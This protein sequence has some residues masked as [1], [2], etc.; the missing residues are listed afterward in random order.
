MSGALSSLDS[1]RCFLEAARARSFRN[2]AHAVGLTPTAFGQRIKQLEGQL[3]ARLFLRTTRSVTLTERGL[4]LV[5]VAERC[6]A[7]AEE[8][9][10]IARGPSGPPPMDLTL[11]TRQELGMSWVVPMRGRL[12]RERPWLNLHLYF[13]SGPD[14]L[15]RVRTLDIDCAVTSSTFTDPKLDSFRLHRED[16]ALVGSSRLL[17]KVPFTRREHA[18]S[19][20]LIDASP[21]MPLFR[22][23]RD[24][25]GA[26]GPLR[27]ARASWLGSIAAIRHQVLAGAGVAVLPSYFVHRDVVAGTLRRV[28]PRV[29]LV[30]DYFRLVFRAADPRRAV[31]ESLAKDM[32]SQPLQ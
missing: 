12:M 1:L 31:F 30:H 16:Y 24:A 5:P 19:H 20:T 11:G 15:L 23:W 29:T 13:S 17:A 32:V 25:R 18:A 8:C 4:A 9:A 7:T 6:L 14:L 10:R 21:D 26:G 28:F 2:A 3:G 27:F 22:Y